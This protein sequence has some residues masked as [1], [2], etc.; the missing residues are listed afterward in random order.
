MRE[1]FLCALLYAGLQRFTIL[2]P[3]SALMSH[4]EENSHCPNCGFQTSHNFCAQCGQETHL[5]KETFWGLVMHFIGH[6]FHYDSKFWQTMKALWFSPGKLT[7]AYMNKQ[8]MRY[9]P[10]ISLYIFISAVYFLVKF[11]THDDFV[12]PGKH[13]T[14]K[15][16]NT[17]LSTVK[18]KTHGELDNFYVDFP[19]TRKPSAIEEYLDRRSE[20][21]KAKHGDVTTYI[22]NK[23]NHNIP[24][25]FFFMIPAMALMLKL[26]FARRKTAYFVDHA[27]FALHYHCFW[28]SLFTLNLMGV[29]TSVGFAIVVLMLITAFIYLIRSMKKV[30]DIGYVRAFFSSFFIVTGYCLFLAIFFLADLAIILAMG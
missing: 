20:T 18:A 2:P 28:F 25:I 5:H 23:A 22:L 12:T 29:G 16:A 7:L 10:P 15:K 4:T 26:L 19:D 9:I 11:T 6:Y 14:A 8:R 1:L 17:S 21:I 30:Y 27:I 13:N 24:K 3:Y